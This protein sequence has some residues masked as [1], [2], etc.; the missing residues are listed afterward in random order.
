MGKNGAGK[1]TLLTNIGLGTVEG[2]PSHLRTIYVQHDDPSDD[3][4]VTVIDEIMTNKYVIEANTTKN[5]AIAALKE[6][7][8]TDTMLNSPRSDLSGGW[9]MKLLIIRAMLS[10]AN[11]LLLDEVS[12]NLFICYF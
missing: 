12:F 7:N 11:V 4:G 8:F 9:K 3:A 1:T 5:E 6:I 2:L 10:K